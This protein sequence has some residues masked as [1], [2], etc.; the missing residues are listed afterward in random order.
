MSA[1]QVVVNQVVVKKFKKLKDINAPKRAK[2]SF[3]FFSNENRNTVKEDLPDL[4]FG[5][6][7][8]EL[9]RRWRED[10]SESDK[11]GYIKMSGDDKDRYKKDMESY[12]PSEEF[13]AKSIAHEKKEKRKKKDPNAPKRPKNAFILFS[14]EMRP[15]I[16]EIHPEWTIGEVG[17][18]L[19]SHW[20]AMSDKDKK[21]FQDQSKKDKVRYD[22][23]MVSYSLNDDVS[24]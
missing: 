14:G 10:V 17:K 18:E 24:S 2:S 21:Q 22:K 5:Q 20:R 6:I 4:T 23:E 1:N 13:L 12:V 15:N 11:N 9:G 16:K 3:M 19:G 7:G 8:K